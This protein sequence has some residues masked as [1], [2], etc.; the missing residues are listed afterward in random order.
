MPTQAADPPG[1]Q[2]N[3]CRLGPTLA[4]PSPVLAWG[5]TAELAHSQA[6][7]DRTTSGPIRSLL[8]ERALAWR[9]SAGRSRSFAPPNALRL[10][11]CAAR[12]ILGT[13]RH[14]RVPELAGVPR[15]LLVQANGSLVQFKPARH[16]HFT[17]LPGK[18]LPKTPCSAIRDKQTAL[19]E[20]AES[21]EAKRRRSSA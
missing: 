14:L 2:N 7:R 12:A 9:C 1:L 6:P 3:R 4:A 16:R 15:M 13:P 17:S 18:P 11:L 19:A 21:E 20:R 5:A 10:S 8:R